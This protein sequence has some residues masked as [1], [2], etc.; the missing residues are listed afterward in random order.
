MA[1]EMEKIAEAFRILA[2]VRLPAGY[3]CEIE[4]AVTQAHLDTTKAQRA[5]HL[6]ATRGPEEAAAALRCGRSQVY[7]LA[8]QANKVQKPDDS[9][10]LA[11]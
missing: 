2:T 11:A 10:T 3:L 5:A 9:R 4:R 8:A 1:S 6:L 7:V